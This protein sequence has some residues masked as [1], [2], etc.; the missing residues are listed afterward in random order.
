VDQNYFCKIYFDLIFDDVDSIS[1]SL[2]FF[3]LIAI[4]MRK[5]QKERTPYDITPIE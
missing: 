4:V 2:F 3:Y 5:P 1:T